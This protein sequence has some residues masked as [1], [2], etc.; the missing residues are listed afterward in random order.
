[1]RSFLER[2]V[3]VMVVLALSPAFGQAVRAQ[4]TRAEQPGELA[5][6]VIT[7]QKRAEPL[8]KAPISVS[9]LDNTALEMRNVSDLSQ[10]ADS[11]PSVA[12]ATT[13]LGNSNYIIRGVGAV[14][15][16]QS[17]T[18]G[19][20]LD[21]TPLQSRALRGASQADPQLYDIARVEVLRGPQ[22]VLFG[23]SAMGGLVRI[24]TNQPDATA[25]AAKIE[26]S[27]AT[28]TDGAESW[29]FKGMFNAPLIQ[30]TLALRVVGSFVHQ[31]G[32]IDDLR[33][34]TGNLS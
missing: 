34:K 5:E 10:V 8:Q 12:F 30:N 32:W 4:E 21:E 29:D 7:A 14:G 31:G 9:V 22:G 17:P 28:I 24:I 1:M 13:G 16:A 20:Y 3:I 11:V 27:A 2:N 23:S 6:I 26:G 19:M 25:R 15:A 18:T 33:P